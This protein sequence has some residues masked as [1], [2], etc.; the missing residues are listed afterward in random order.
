MLSESSAG[1]LANQLFLARTAS[2]SSFPIC[3]RLS[4][5]DLR[6]SRCDNCYPN[7]AIDKGFR[8]PVAPRKATATAPRRRGVPLLEAK[9]VF[10][11]AQKQKAPLAERLLHFFR[12][13]Y[14][15]ENPL[16][17]ITAS[18]TCRIR[19]DAGSSRSARLRSSSAR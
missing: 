14:Q 16:I 17:K 8:G 12:P 13:R 5:N 9:I 19:P 18:S 10:A 4:R 1:K 11:G 7:Q 3:R 15:R 2:T 6:M